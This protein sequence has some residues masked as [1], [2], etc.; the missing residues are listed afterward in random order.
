M[1]S[2][3]KID[4]LINDRLFEYAVIQEGNPIFGFPFTFRKKTGIMG[5]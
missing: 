5:S 3:N 2:S 4:R 1:H